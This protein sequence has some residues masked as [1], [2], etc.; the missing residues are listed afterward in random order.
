MPNRAEFRVRALVKGPP[1]LD[2]DA[3]KAKPSEEDVGYVAL[4]GE[5]NEHLY[6]HNVARAKSSVRDVGVSLSVADRA[7]WAHYRKCLSVVQSGRCPGRYRRKPARDR[8][9]RAWV[10]LRDEGTDMASLSPEHIMLRIVEMRRGLRRPR[11]PHLDARREEP[12]AP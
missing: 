3:L 12:H 2:V 8:F 7:L 1:Y 5:A 9:L 11:P 6:V 10:S 4:F